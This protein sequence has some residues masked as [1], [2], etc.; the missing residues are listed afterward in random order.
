MNN[1]PISAMLGTKVNPMASWVPRWNR[2]SPPPH[3]R[4]SRGRN[5]ASNEAHSRYIVP[6]KSSH[7]RIGLRTRNSPSSVAWSVD[8]SR[9]ATISEKPSIW[10]ELIRSFVNACRP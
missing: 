1:S 8:N 2:M 9:S 4:W 10:N 3:S 5:A 7:P 6:L